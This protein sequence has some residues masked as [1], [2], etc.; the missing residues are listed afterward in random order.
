MKPIGAHWPLDINIIQQV[1]NR[2]FNNE[3]LERNQCLTASIAKQSLVCSSVEWVCGPNSQFK[4]LLS[5][6]KML[7]IQ[8]WRCCQSSM[9]SDALK[10]KL[11]TGKFDFSEFKTTG[12]LGKKQ[13]LAQ[14]GQ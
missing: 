12:N 10:R 7:N 2:K 1:G 13:K 5:K 4:V 6:L 11:R 14:L 3:W 9:I 8:H